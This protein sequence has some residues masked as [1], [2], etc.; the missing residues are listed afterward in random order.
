MLIQG[1]SGT[2]K[3]LVARAIHNRS[4]RRSRPLIEVNCA[5]IPRE[6]FESE[7]FGHV[8]GAF[9]GA[10][11]DRAG[12]FQAATGGTLF[13]DEVGEIS[14]ELQAQCSE[15][16]RR[17]SSNA[18]AR[19]S[20][21]VDVR[22]LAATNGDLQ[23]EVVAG[24]FR[25]DLVLPPQCFSDRAAPTPRPTRRSPATAAHFVEQAARRYCR[26][27]PRLTVRAIKILGD[28]TAGLETFGNCSTSLNAPSC[29]PLAM[30][31]DWM[32]C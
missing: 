28:V 4:S 32:V 20:R 10:L 14:L 1:E 27:A 12:R 23:Q 3:E 5:S 24:R 31:C 15:F 9:T 18:S 30:C 26:P 8:K 29:C 22:V 19:W 11:R 6:L 7:F 2:G 13:L 17:V 16:C 25:P 21:T